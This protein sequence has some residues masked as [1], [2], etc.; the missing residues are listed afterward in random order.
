MKNNFDIHQWQA[1]HLKKENIKEAFDTEFRDIRDMAYRDAERAVNNTPD[2]VVNSD[3]YGH[4][5]KEYLRT[6]ESL[7]G[8]LLYRQGQQ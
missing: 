8:D 4:Y 6:Y 1:K 5:V 3:Y 2:S 7:T